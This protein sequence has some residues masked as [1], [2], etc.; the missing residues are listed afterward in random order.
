MTTPHP[1]QDLADYALLTALFALIVI[2]ILALL[3]DR[4]AALDHSV[5]GGR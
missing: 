1:G 4:I 5:A 2:G 3:E